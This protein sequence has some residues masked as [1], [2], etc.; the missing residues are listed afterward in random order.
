MVDGSYIWRPSTTPQRSPYTTWLALAAFIGLC[1]AVGLGSAQFMDN[2]QSSWFQTLER[3]AW[4]PPD[5]LF[6]PVWTALYA[7]MGTAAWLVWKRRGFGG[8]PLAMSLFGIQL[9]LNG[10]WT[11]IFFGLHEPGLA[12][13]D[14]SALWL[15]VAGTT[16]VFARHSSKAAWIMTPYLLWTTY[17]WALN[18]QIWRLNA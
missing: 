2:A 1:E 6:A 10:L 7:M 13:L 14:A 12:L 16:V 9:V 18:W 15:A 4:G 17:A 11:P 5:W 3:P 8:A